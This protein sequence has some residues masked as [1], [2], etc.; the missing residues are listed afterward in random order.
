[1]TTS[2]SSSAYVPAADSTNNALSTDVIG[3]K[4]DAAAAG[5]VTT[6]ESIMAYAKQSVTTADVI[7][8]DLT[9]VVATT[10]KI[11]EINTPTNLPQ[12]AAL[13]LFTVTGT[14]QI[15]ALRAFIT[16]QVGAV[17]NATKFTGGPGSDDLCATVELNAAAANSILSITGTIA[18]PMIINSG[19]FESQ[20]NNITVGP[21]D[22][23]IDCAGNDGGGGGDGLL[24]YVLVYKPVSLTGSVVAA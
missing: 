4:T 22:I 11:V 8:V 1:M 14:V 6:T 20:A 19:S 9:T 12:T 24:T 17:A 2:R 23:K 21:G 5:A 7:A 16:Q 15:V 13:S 3:N 10:E 18:N